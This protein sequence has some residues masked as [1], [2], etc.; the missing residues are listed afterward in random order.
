MA[1]AP[2]KYTPNS[3][4]SGAADASALLY[5]VDSRCIEN[6]SKIISKTKIYALAV[7]KKN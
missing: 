3:P 7:E 1:D 2:E 4:D 5:R 6:V